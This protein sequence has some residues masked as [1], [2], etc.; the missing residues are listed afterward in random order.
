MNRNMDELW[1]DRALLSEIGVRLQRERL[2]RN[3]TQGELAASSGLSRST[4][5]KMEAGENFSM[6]TLIRVLR[7]LHLLARLDLLV[8][9]ARVSPIQLADMSG[10]TRERASGS[11][12]KD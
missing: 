12:T 5:A 1:A 7:A 9:E 3:L 4:I 11:R 8:P 10:K 6:E 2:N